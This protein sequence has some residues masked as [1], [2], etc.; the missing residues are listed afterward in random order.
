MIRTIL[1]YAFLH[2]SNASHLNSWDSFCCQDFFQQTDV[3]PYS[4][5]NLANTHLGLG[6]IDLTLPAIRKQ[7]VD[8]TDPS[9]E[10]YGLWTDEC[11]MIIGTQTAPDAN[12]VQ[13]RRAIEL[14]DGNSGIHCINLVRTPHD[15]NTREADESISKVSRK[16]D[17]LYCLQRY[18]FICAPGYTFWPK[19]NGGNNK[20][21]GNVPPPEVLDNMTLGERSNGDYNKYACYIKG[22]EPSSALNYNDDKCLAPQTHNLNYRCYTPDYNGRSGSY[23]RLGSDGHKIF[24]ISVSCKE[25]ENTFFTDAMDEGGAYVTTG[26]M[27]ENAMDIMYTGPSGD[28]ETACQDT[29]VHKPDPPADNVPTQDV[30]DKVF[31]G[32]C[33][34]KY[35]GDVAVK[36]AKNKLTPHT[37]DMDKFWKQ[38]HE[39]Q[40]YGRE[41]GTPSTE[42]QLIHNQGTYFAS[43]QSCQSFGVQE[44]SC[45]HVVTPITLSLGNFLAN[46]LPPGGP[47]HGIVSCNSENP[48]ECH[49]VHDDEEF[50]IPAMDDKSPYNHGIHCG[51]ANTNYT[52][53]AGPKKDVDIGPHSNFNTCLECMQSLA[54]TCAEGYSFNVAQQKC[55]PGGMCTDTSTECNVHPEDTLATHTLTCVEHAGVDFVSKEH[56]QKQSYVVHR[57]CVWD[58]ITQKCQ[59]GMYFED[60]IPHEYEHCDAVNTFIPPT[61]AFF[62]RRDQHCVSTTYQ[63]FRKCQTDRHVQH[64]VNCFNSDVE[65]ADESVDRVV[66]RPA[67]GNIDDI[68][69]IPITKD[70]CNTISSRVANKACEIH[71]I[72]TGQTTD[73]SGDVIFELNE[74]L[75]E[76]NAMEIFAC[77]ALLLPIFGTGV[78]IANSVFRWNEGC[79]KQCCGNKRRGR[80]IRRSSVTDVIKSEQKKTAKETV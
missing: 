23:E 12:G 76:L 5:A 80:N 72:I 7:C 75:K 35:F 56:C 8:S 20:C 40:A 73:D 68:K 36:E 10:H 33:C 54:L 32:F 59:G 52:P 25:L 79:L 46:L 49:V 9:N 1:I 70:I 13:H 26:T 34:S 4:T 58:Q 67:S 15:I 60:R 50:Q 66:C 42:S 16:R 57:K 74:W 30:I 41:W 47:P 19:Q 45:G 2:L 44:T 78:C 11:G 31:G 69:P 14:D 18:Q 38:Y 51:D 22:A 63:E 65:D 21:V 37:P 53:I 17:C 29:G 62:Y 3:D 28:T 48:P 55:L 24:P 39:F 27:G 71:R 43:N 64:P 6:D 77:V 61:S